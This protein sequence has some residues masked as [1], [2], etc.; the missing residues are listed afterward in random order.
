MDEMTR[1]DLLLDVDGILANFIDPALEEVA[2]L[3]GLRHH[4]DEV[5]QW[6]IMECLGIPDDVAEAAYARMKREG[7]CASLPVYPGAQEG[8]EMLRSVCNLYI[9]TSP[10]G[11]AHWAHEREMWL[12]EHFRI[13]GKTV[14]STSAK[15]KCVG[16]VFVDDKSS[17]LEKWSAKHPRD[18]AVR[19]SVRSNSQDI[20]NGIQT[21]NWAE[22]R[23]IVVGLSHARSVR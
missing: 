20:W 2:A 3:T 12:W 9:V 14:I 5:T 22:L 6:D 17:N 8:V 11:G 18:C 16:D 23:G 4:H 10:L 7:F 19:W 15:Y 1:L 13:P 21:N